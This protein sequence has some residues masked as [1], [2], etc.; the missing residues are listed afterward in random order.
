MKRVR[1]IISILLISLIAVTIFQGCASK[2]GDEEEA[3]DDSETIIYAGTQPDYP[4]F[5]Y[6]DDNDELTGYEV[7]VLKAI[8][9]KLDGYK[10]EIQALSWDALFLSLESNKLQIIADQVAINPEREE[11]YYFSDPYFDAQTVIITKKGRTDIKTLKDLEG[12][13]VQATVGDSYSQLLEKYNEENGNKIN[14]K[15]SDATSM[16]DVFLDIQNG[17]Y[18]ATVNDPIMANSIIEKQGLNVEV[19]GEPIQNDDMGIVFNKDDKGKELR[20][21]INPILKE[22]KEDG[23]LDELSKKWT[24]GSYIPK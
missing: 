8:D 23:T 2:K 10:I 9:E 4:P 20:D 21:L 22:L 15:Y 7:D 1:K 12:K 19:V 14:L 17:K 3:K 11:K 24:G 5:C 6:L 13:N 18:D 16:G